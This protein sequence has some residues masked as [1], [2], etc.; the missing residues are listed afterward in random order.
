MRGGIVYWPGVI[1]YRTRLDSLGRELAFKKKSSALWPIYNFFLY[2]LS[3]FQYMLGRCYRFTVIRWPCV[4]G[5]GWERKDR[6]SSSFEGAAVNLVQGSSNATIRSLILH[7]CVGNGKGGQRRS[8]SRRVLPWHH[9]TSTLLLNLSL[10]R[11]LLSRFLPRALARCTHSRGQLQFL[12]SNLPE[13]F[14]KHR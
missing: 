14:V 11:H 1:V 7:Q 13:S 3:F 5:E 8:L 2:S 6:F 10:P 12:A 9:E 4:S